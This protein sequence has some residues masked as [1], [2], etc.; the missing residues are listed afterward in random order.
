MKY[1]TMKCRGFWLPENA[2]QTKISFM[3]VLVAK[4]DWDGIEDADDE[5]IFFY[6]DGKQLK[7]GDVI[8]DEFIIIEIEENE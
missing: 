5:C 8:A 7:R 3:D 1:E 2:E 4:Y 6:M